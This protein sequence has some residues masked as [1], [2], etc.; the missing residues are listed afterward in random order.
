[1]RLVKSFLLGTAAGLAAVAG[2][3][4]AQSNKP[5]QYV[6]ICSLYGD[7]YY[8]IPGTDTCI[9]ITGNAQFDAGWNTASGAQDST[10][11]GLAGT[12]TRASSTF[13]TRARVDFNLDTRTMSAYGTART[14]T[15]LRAD[16]S[17]NQAGTD[18]PAVSAPRAFIQWA[19]WTFGRVKSFSD[20]PTPYDNQWTEPLT[21]APNR[22][23]TA[24][25][26]TNEISYTWELG[27]GMSLHVGAG[28]RRSKPVANLS[29][30]VWTPNVSN[31]V[32]PT[33]SVA[34]EA[35]P[36]PFAAF[37][38]SQAWGRWET[39]VT[40]NSL[41]ATYYTAPTPGFA[42][43]TL[44]VASTLCDHPSDAWGWA[45]ASG[46]TIN[47]PWITP[48]DT[49]NVYAAFGHGASAYVAGQNLDS[50]ALYGSG[51]TLAFGA[52]T[53]AVYLNGSGLQLTTTWTVGG[54]FEHYWTPQLSSTVFG[55]YTQ[56]SYNGTVTSGRWFCGGGGAAVQGPII[57]AGAAC[58]PGFSFS[59]FGSHTDWYPVPSLRLGVEVLY[60]SIGTG[61]NGTD[62]TLP[63]VGA[64]PAGVYTAKNEGVASF[65]FRAQ[66][67]WPAAGD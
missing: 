33:S 51:N 50:P 49:F 10:Y 7:G 13:A 64:R 63:T 37:K 57:P 66:R 14:Y 9:R 58:D 55:S 61:F 54:A 8:Y 47:T 12:R 46:T 1:M 39:S 32:T 19:G 41:R 25:R 6:K 28:E 42:G 45:V 65:M 40:A 11:T 16:S 3:Q 22:I 44:G 23:D 24:N 29:N 34:G 5:V 31:I 59:V 62:V 48:G 53:D 67:Q 20:V 52:L 27:N 43:C 38:V 17:T 18:T 2:A 60:T 21:D 36:N 15:R 56:I 35:T 30:F 4:A 26:G